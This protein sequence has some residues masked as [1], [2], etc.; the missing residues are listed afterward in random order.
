MSMFDSNGYFFDSYVIDSTVSNTQLSQSVITF[1][2][3]NML[4]IHGNYQNII[5]LKNPINPQ[6]AAT[7]FYVDSLGTVLTVTL[8]NTTPSLIASNLKGSFVITVSNEILNGPSAIFHVTKSSNTHT[9]GLARTVSSPGLASNTQ[10]SIQWNINEGIY[11]YKTNNSYDGS[12][13]IKFI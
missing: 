2:S 11:L 12:Y 10:L 4:D 6:D 1:S 9:A 3:L 8:S 7:K 5:N 13:T